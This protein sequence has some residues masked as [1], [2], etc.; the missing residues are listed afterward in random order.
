M[1]VN[2]QEA[3]ILR[4]PN[5]LLMKI[6]EYTP[7]RFDISMVCVKF[8]DIV[9][10]LEQKSHKIALKDEKMVSGDHRLAYK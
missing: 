7:E 10:T 4:L 2:N 6:I 9:C 8:H 1:T 3:M 5:E